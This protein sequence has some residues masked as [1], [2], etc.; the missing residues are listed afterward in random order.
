[1][2]YD[3]AE[4]NSSMQKYVDRDILAGV[5]GALL[6]GRDLV[7]QHCSGWADK[8]QAIPLREDHLFR[9]FS[10]TKLITSI[11]ILLLME[12]GKLQ[13]DDRLEQYL[14]QMA[15]RRVLLPGATSLDQTEAA[16]SAISLRQCLNHTSGLAY[17]LLDHGSLLYR[18]YNEAKVL[19]AFT[20]LAEM[21][22]ALAALPL[23]FHPGQAWEYSIASDVLARVV[24]VVSGERFD[25]FIG[26]R[27]FVPLQMHDSGF[28][29]P[30]EQ[31]HR[32]TAYY[33]GVDVSN[34]LARGLRRLERSPYPGAFTMP[35][36][37]LSGGGGLVSSLPDMLALLRSFMPG[38]TTL[39]RPQTIALMMEN[40]LPAGMGL[41]FPGIGAV[42]GKGF[43]LGGAVTLAPSS[44]D[45]PTAHGEFE[46]GGIAGTHW[47]IS[48]RHNIAGILMTQRLMS[49]WHPFSFEFKRHAY[50]ALGV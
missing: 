8:E 24:E 15:Q 2:G 22:D 16:R 31:V 4:V 20:S 50:A 9:V 21:V 17:G 13:L 23:S 27:I 1:M 29:V 45:P 41:S 47:W 18:A 38:G 34:V 12:D 3:F 19:N 35:V 26:R 30:P 5:S 48:P 10:N 14:P 25:D 7:Y 33:A 37:R 40:H 6:V 44:I 39:L 11:A 36:A 43:G 49:F 28:H 46:W 32:L 42:P